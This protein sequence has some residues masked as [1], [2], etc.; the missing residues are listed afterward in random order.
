MNPED[1]SLPPRKRTLSDF[2]VRDTGIGIPE[3][4]HQLVFEAFQQAD[5]STRRKYG[6]TGLGLSIS[7]ELARLL[8]GVIGLASQPGQGAEFRV[9]LPQFKMPAGQLSA[10]A[11]TVADGSREDRFHGGH[12]HGSTLTLTEVPAE[13]P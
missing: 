10:A 2:S 4:K 7:R 5:G 6:G 1:L 9:T 11:S 8:G 13:N 12:G 3:D